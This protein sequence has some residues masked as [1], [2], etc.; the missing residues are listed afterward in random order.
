MRARSSEVVWPKPTIGV[1]KFGQAL[2]SIATTQCDK[3]SQ[4][5]RIATCARRKKSTLKKQCPLTIGYP[6]VNIQ[7]ESNRSEIE[8]VGRRGHESLKSNRQ[9]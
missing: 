9:F 6:E 4:K 5:K 3:T 1:T 7:L 8:E 2:G